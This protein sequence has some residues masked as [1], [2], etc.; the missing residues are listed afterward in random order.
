MYFFEQQLDFFDKFIN[1]IDI[2]ILDV[3][4]TKFQLMCI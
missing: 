3:F 1:M 4:V 2:I